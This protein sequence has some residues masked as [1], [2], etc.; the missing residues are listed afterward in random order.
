MK[1]FGSFCLES[2]HCFYAYYCLAITG[3]QTAIFH[4]I[5][6]FLIFGI[7]G[8]RT[9]FVSVYLLK[10]SCNLK[11]CLWLVSDHVLTGCSSGPIWT[12]LNVTVMTDLCSWYITAVIYWNFWLVVSVFIANPFCYYNLWLV[13][14]SI[15]WL[16]HFNCYQYCIYIVYGL[17]FTSVDHTRC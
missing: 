10:I 1:I 3:I 8:C 7:K 9:C 14:A 11:N 2:S 4:S 12:S 13:F 5:H 16:L 17:K 15:L 6:L